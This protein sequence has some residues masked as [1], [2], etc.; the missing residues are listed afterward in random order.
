MAFD[1]HF[2][3][4]SLTALKQDDIEGRYVVALSGGADSTAL[5]IALSECVSSEK[6]VAL[7]FD[8]A[9]HSDSADWA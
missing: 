6:V 8:H 9:I 5:L 2:L 1:S 3:K 7:H 4:R